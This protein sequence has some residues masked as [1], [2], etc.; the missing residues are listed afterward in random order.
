MCVA[1]NVHM[2]RVDS[3]NKRHVDRAQ[4]PAAT[5]ILSTHAEMLIEDL[6]FCK[7]QKYKIQNTKEQPLQISG[8]LFIFNR[9]K[10]WSRFVIC[11]E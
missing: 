7:I 2:F 1:L 8:H 3:I 11:S 4:Y 10:S 6:Y 9:G 5:I